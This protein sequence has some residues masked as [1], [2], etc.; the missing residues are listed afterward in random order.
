MSRTVLHIV[1]IFLCFLYGTSKVMAQCP[2]LTEEQLADRN[3]LDAIII[4]EYS[5]KLREGTIR[6]PV[7]TERMDV[8]LEAG[9]RYRFMVLN[10]DETI[11][12]AVLQ[13]YDHR[14]LLG[15]SFDEVTGIDLRRFEYRTE[16]PAILQLVF[17]SKRGRKTCATALFSMVLEDT[18]TVLD[19]RIG[20]LEDRSIE[21]LYV[22]IDNEIDITASGVN[23][24]FFKVTA[25]SGKITGSAG[26]YI[27]RFTEPGRTNIK[28]ETY[29]RDSTLHEEQ[30]TVFRVSNLPDPKIS[31]AGITEGKI[32]SDQLR[33]PYQVS[34]LTIKGLHP[35]GYELIEFSITASAGDVRLLRSNGH[36]LSARQRNF[37]STLR[38]GGEFYIREAKVRTPKGE[39]IT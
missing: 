6:R 10:S 11:G 17:S 35:P 21:T 1:L 37:I 38:E 9:I 2:Q 31:L 27:T 26:R 4:E 30:V 25:S 3:G 7:R 24:G 13:L 39:V 8:T 16:E 29:T 5:V 32:N 33:S 12:E 18:T 19:S 34:L 23:G 22:G 15:S 20:S 28:V 14:E 36:L